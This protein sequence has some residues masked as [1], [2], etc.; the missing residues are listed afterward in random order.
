MKI[1]WTLIVLVSFSAQGICKEMN[2]EI[3]VAESDHV[4]TMESKLEEA[5]NSFTFNG[6][7]IHPGCVR[8]FNVSP[9]DSLPPI[10]RAVDVE[11]CISSNENYMEFKTSDEGYVSY[12]YDSGG[13]EKGYFAYK[14]LGKTKDGPHVLDTRTN[15]GGTMIAVTVFLVRFGVE[16]YSFFTDDDKQETAERLVMTC[17]GQIP[18]GDKDTGSVELKGDKLI[19]GASQYREKEEVIQLD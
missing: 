16:K 14:Y 5:D 2:S 3:V 13:G 12:E 4:Q 11:A 17:G 15:T 18:R 9:A 7:A 1:F 19:L 10:V 6:K 8:E